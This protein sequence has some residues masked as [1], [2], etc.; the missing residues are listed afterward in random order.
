MVDYEYDENEEVEDA[1]EWNKVRERNIKINIAKQLIANGIVDTRE[2]NQK[3]LKELFSFKESDVLYVAPNLFDIKEDCYI[4]T[5]AFSEFVDKVVQSN[6]V[7][8]DSLPAAEADFIKLYGSFR[9]EVEKDMYRAYAGD[10]YQ[11]VLDKLKSIIP[12]IHWGRLPIFNKYLI[13]NREKD[14]ELEMLEFYE[15]PDCL[16]ALLNEVK[17]KGIVLSNKSDETLN[18]KIEFKVYTRRWGHEDV[19]SIKRT[20][21]GW[22]CGFIAIQGECKKNGEGGLFSNLDHDSIFY[23]K[24]GVAYAMEKL[25]E[26]AD[27]GVIDFDELSER[28]Q[29]VAD[30]ISEVEKSIN[31]QPEWVGYY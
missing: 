14:P 19:Y 23:P 3:K 8:K 11:K 26:D 20:V 28:V 30:W 21:S 17:N 15:H 12:I 1:K 27:D 18:K 9:D 2:F 25:W 29:Q 22:Y 7:V 4:M 5:P 24:E 31:A 10:K 13:Y 6:K 16:N